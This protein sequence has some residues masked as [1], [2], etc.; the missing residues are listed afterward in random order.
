MFT[1]KDY[2]GE[3][4]EEISRGGPASPEDRSWIGA[5]EDS[6]MTLRTSLPNASISKPKCFHDGCSVQAIYSSE[7]EFKND[8]GSFHYRISE[9]WKHGGRIVPPRL[10]DDGTITL[11]WI[12]HSPSRVTAT[13][14]TERSERANDPERSSGS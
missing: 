4:D 1:D 9:V 13:P 8:N 12:M 6:L 5:A 11:T 7:N 10:N 2:S 3:L 14:T